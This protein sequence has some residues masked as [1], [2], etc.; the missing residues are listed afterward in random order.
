M[1]YFLVTTLSIVDWRLVGLGGG[2]GICS[3]GCEFSERAINRAGLTV[4]SK[5]GCFSF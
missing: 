4:G 5:T 1:G 2:P 3:Q